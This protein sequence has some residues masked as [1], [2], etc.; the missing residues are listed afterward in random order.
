MAFLLHSRTSEAARHDS[1]CSVLV[2]RAV[3]AVL[4]KHTLMSSTVQFAET[5]EVQFFTHLAEQLL[6]VKLLIRSNKPF[7]CSLSLS[8]MQSAYFFGYR[9]EVSVA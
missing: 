4:G 8:G 1:A 2:R 6:V 5:P 3:D 9:L 7:L